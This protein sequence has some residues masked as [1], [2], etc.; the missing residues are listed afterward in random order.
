VCSRPDCDIARDQTR[1]RWRFPVHKEGDGADD[2]GT[3]QMTDLEQAALRQVFSPDDDEPVRRL[4]AEG[5]PIQV[6]GEDS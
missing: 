6:A 2:D 1:A 5:S 3:L 4:S